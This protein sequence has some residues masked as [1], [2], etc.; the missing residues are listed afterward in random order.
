MSKTIAKT[1]EHIVR[2]HGEEGRINFTLFSD[3]MGD[4]AVCH[5]MP[6]W[7]RRK[8]WTVGDYVITSKTGTETGSPQNKY[9]IEGHVRY[10][11]KKWEGF[12]IVCLFP[13]DKDPKE[14]TCNQ[15]IER[16]VEE[17]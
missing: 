6:P 8:A 15:C 13:F 14:P 3:D 11:I 17:A 1:V 16:R 2:S 12:P 4:E 7:G 5:E 9:L 10:P